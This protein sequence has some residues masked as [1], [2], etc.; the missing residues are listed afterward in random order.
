MARRCFAAQVPDASA[1]SEW[2]LFRFSWDLLM[3]WRDRA[4]YVW[5]TLVA[6]TIAECRAWPLPVRWHWVYY[7]F[8]PL[9]LVWKQTAGRVAG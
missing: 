6:P 7:F 5:Y 2:A 8:R 4:R 1:V 3:T 9:R